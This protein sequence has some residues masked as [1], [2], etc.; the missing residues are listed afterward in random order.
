MIFD[1]LSSPC[2]G[3]IWDSSW[4]LQKTFLLSWSPAAPVRVSPWWLY[5]YSFRLPRSC[6]KY[7]HNW[8]SLLLPR[9]EWAISE[10]LQYLQRCF[11]AIILLVLLDP[12]HRWWNETCLETLPWCL[13]SDQSRS[14][15]GEGSCRF[16]FWNN[17]T[18]P[19]FHSSMCFSLFR[20][21]LFS[22]TK[23]P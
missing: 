20:A 23:S 16:H 8:I 9:I 14:K 11:K 21:V 3:D 5:L 7:Q 4:S 1:S 13:C 22:S 2:D 17:Q 12:R 18:F 10:H 6:V 19:H 15:A